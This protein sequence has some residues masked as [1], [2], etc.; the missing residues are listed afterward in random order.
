MVVGDLQVFDNIEDL[1]DGTTRFPLS[2]NN[3]QTSIRARIGS[4]V[5]VKATLLVS[6]IFFKFL[7]KVISLM[8]AVI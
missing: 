4:I 8:V 1:F 7:I 2:V 6:M 3:V 5:D